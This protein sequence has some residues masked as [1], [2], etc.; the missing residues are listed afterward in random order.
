MQYPN[1]LPRQNNE[2][3]NVYALDALG[4]VL[5]KLPRGDVV[6]ASNKARDMI[7]VRKYKKSADWSLPL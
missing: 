4:V 3:L 2:V 5:G 7:S 1:A 6:A